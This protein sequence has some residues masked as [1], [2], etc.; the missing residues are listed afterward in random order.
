MLNSA[1]WKDTMR[2][3]CSCLGEPW[4]LISFV[5][6][7]HKLWGEKKN[8]K[9]FILQLTYDLVMDTTP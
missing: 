7:L 9:Q 1:R 8:E 3:L 4:G 2:I 6:D 5:I